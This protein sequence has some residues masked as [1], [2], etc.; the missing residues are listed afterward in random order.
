MRCITLLLSRAWLTSPIDL[1]AH[2]Q[3]TPFFMGRHCQKNAHT[4][5]SDTLGCSSQL[6]YLA[7]HYRRGCKVP[8]TPPPPSYQS[9]SS[10]LMLDEGSSIISV[11]N[12]WRRSHLDLNK[13][14][15]CGS[16]TQTER[17]K[18]PKTHIDMHTRQPARVLLCAQPLPQFAEIVPSVR[19]RET[20][21]SWRAQEGSRRTKSDETWYAGLAK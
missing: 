1:V 14:L 19:L 9:S 17:L 3:D 4:S 16:S 15:S 2:F 20:P 18:R 13:I 8:C 21:S 6:E 10:P 7:F 5:I 11:H 12:K